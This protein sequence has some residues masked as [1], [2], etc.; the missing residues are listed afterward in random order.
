MGN[1]NVF[2]LLNF[3]KKRDFKKDQ[4]T[5][6]LLSQTNFEFQAKLQQD[7][8]RQQY[9]F[10]SRTCMSKRKTRKSKNQ[11]STIT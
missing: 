11:L 9:Y 3:M 10:H 7:A 1:K 8:L 2:W 5:I 6:K 4:E